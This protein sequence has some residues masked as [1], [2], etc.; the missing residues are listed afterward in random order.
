VS[1]K[2]D[3]KNQIKIS[4]SYSLCF[5][6]YEEAL[7]SLLKWTRDHE[8]QSHQ[9]ICL[10][11]GCWWISEVW[12]ILFQQLNNS[13]DIFDKVDALNFSESGFSSIYLQD[14]YELFKI[15]TKEGR[16]FPSIFVNKT[17]IWTAYENYICPNFIKQEGLAPDK[18]D[19][20]EEEEEEEVEEE[21][22]E[23]YSETIVQDLEDES[24]LKIIKEID[25]EAFLKRVYLD[26]DVNL[27]NLFK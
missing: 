15:C 21:E 16:N 2:M 12:P 20:E 6:E 24:F 23:E 4:F 11:L 25:S 14:L 9:K 7:E 17:P 19:Q 18:L 10:D 26:D 27:H 8:K 13:R 3:K 5:G 22:E 1:A